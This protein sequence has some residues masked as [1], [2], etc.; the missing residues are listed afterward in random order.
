MVANFQDEHLLWAKIKE[1]RGL[2]IEMQTNSC[3]VLASNEAIK[4]HFQNLSQILNIDDINRNVQ[5]L[6]EKIIQKGVE[7]FLYLNSCENQEV[8]S[9]WINFYGK[10]I[11]KPCCFGFDFEYRSIRVAVSAG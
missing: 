2:N 1:L 5:N 4:G 9:Y 6:S 7:M 10:I 11:L 3:F 8:K